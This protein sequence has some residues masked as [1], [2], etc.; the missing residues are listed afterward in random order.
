[1]TAVTIGHDPI[2]TTELPSPLGSLVAGAT[3]DGIC[4]LEF[5]GRQRIDEHFN[6]LRPRLRPGVVQGDNDHLARLRDQIHAYFAGSL[7]V[8]TVPLVMTGTPFE[9]RVW[10]ALLG[11]P[12]GKTTSYGELARAIGEPALAARAVGRANGRNRIAIVIPCHRVIGKDRT[13]VG[14]GGG[15]W[16]K[17]RLIELEDPQRRLI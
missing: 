2:V 8:F 9:E 17:Q 14:Y 5:A 13:L 4:L 11:V 15:L 3:R 16:R 10:T 12:Y 6:A 1:M 7:T